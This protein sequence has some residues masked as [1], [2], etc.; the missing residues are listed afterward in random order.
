MSPDYYR[1]VWT[2][3]IMNKILDEKI[4][5]NPGLTRSEIVEGFKE[6]MESGVYERDFFGQPRMR[7]S[8]NCAETCNEK[9]IQ[10][11]VVARNIL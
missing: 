9:Q 8:R 4:P 1:R 6:L 10:A 3:D 5:W 11:A 2:T 7:S